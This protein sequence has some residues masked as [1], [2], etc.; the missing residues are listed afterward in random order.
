MG[1]VISDPRSE[2]GG[3]TGTTEPDTPGISGQVPE[4]I[5][6]IH[7]LTNQGVPDRQ[8]IFLRII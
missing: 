5:I 4:E 2:Q 1:Q 8:Q 3:E 7:D 6:K